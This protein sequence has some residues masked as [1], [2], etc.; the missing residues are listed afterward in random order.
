MGAV[1]IG[2]FG[3]VTEPSHNLNQLLA[4]LGRG[5]F[6]IW[7]FGTFF[8]AVLIITSTFM[9]KRLPSKNTHRMRLIRGM[10]Y[11]SASGI[12]SAHCLLLAKSAV[13]LLVRTIAD[14]NNQFNRWQSWMI[15]LGL[16][17][18]A[19]TQLYYLHRGLKLCSTSVL[20]PFVFCIYNIVA[21]LDGLIYFDQGS[22]LPVRDAA[23]IAVGTV[24]LLG[25]VFALSWRLQDDAGIPGPSVVDIKAPARVMTPRTILQPG[26]GLA[27]DSEDDSEEETPLL[28]PADEETAVSPVRPL[29]T[30]P[31]L[32]TQ[33]GPAWQ[34]PKARRKNRALTKGSLRPAKLRKTATVTEETSE[35]WDELNDRGSRLSGEYSPHSMRSPSFSRLAGRRSASGARRAI[36]LPPR[37]L[38]GSERLSKMGWGLWDSQRRRSKEPAPAGRDLA[39][40]PP[41][42]E[43]TDGEDTEGEQ[44]TQRRGRG[45]SMGDR[46][47]SSTS[48]EAAGQGWFK[49]KWWKK[50]WKSGEEHHE[51]GGRAGL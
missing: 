24:V 37:R 1:L 31:L 23:L 14:R 48:E 26:F 44:S 10:A 15:L 27:D 50:R 43:P 34:E 12:L 7:L 30:T 29:E 5:Q 28:R 49:M 2:I 9:L 3:S 51:E 21:I 40:P 41:V 4:L 42:S 47:K 20:Y 25:G 6:L 17:F 45:W 11:G 36:T 18:L 13:E 35:L 46:G 32:R 22:R 33:T 16:V 38:S 39:S 8:V 19:L